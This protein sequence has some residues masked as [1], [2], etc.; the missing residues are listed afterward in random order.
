[1]RTRRVCI[2]RHAYYPSDVRVSREVNAL[3][4][5]G[6]EVEIVC[7]RHDGQ[8]RFESRD[9]VTIH[10]VP[11][12]H[13]RDRRLRY[14]FEYATSVILIGGLA[15]ALH[16]RRPFDIVQVNTM[17]DFMLF[18]ATVPK[19]LGARLVLDMHDLMPELYMARFGADA[20]HPLVRALALQ[21]G[22]SMRFA[23]RVIT[24]TEEFKRILERRHGKKEIP[25][26]MNC[27]DETVLPR[28][29]PKRPSSVVDGATADRFVLISHGV[30]LERLGYDTAVRAVALLRDKIPGLELRIVGDGEYVPYLKALADDLGVA[31]CLSFIKYVP[32]NQIAELVGQADLGIVANK[33]DGFAD[34]LLPTKL[35]EFVWLGIPAVVA[36]TR[37]IAN[38]FDDSMVAYFSP[39]DERQLAQRVWEL[40]QRPERRYE[41]AVNAS[42]FFDRV[43]WARE[44]ERYR[45]L[46][47]NLCSNQQLSTASAQ[48]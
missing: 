37:T 36:R 42:R 43:D 13:R 20:D 25:V 32:L 10:R 24:V 21:E 5:G 35:L 9:G 1:V 31:A 18:A 8:P 45:H 7:L 38:Y 44:S 27:P 39:G 15:T 46:L 16:L 4:A 26:I 19:L 23:D 22:V 29:E 12:G 17:P 28:R 30:I 6:Y 2:L 11:I 47:D 34:L 14:M 40:Y 48:R 41:L 3:I 33:P